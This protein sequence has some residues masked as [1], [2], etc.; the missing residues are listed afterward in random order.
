MKGRT[1]ISLVLLCISVSAAQKPRALSGTS[2]ELNTPLKLAIEKLEPTEFGYN[3]TVR[4]TN[5]GNRALT[6]ALSTPPSGMALQSLD[7][8]Q[9]DDKIGWETAGPCRDV[10]PSA[11]MTLQPKSTMWDVVPIFA[12]SKVCPRRIMGLQGRVRAVLYF[13]YNDQLAFERH[14]PAL[15]NVVSEAVE[16]PPLRQS[17]Q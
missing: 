16:L 10:L 13:A 8:Q 9:W 7:V 12:A 1:I 4:V 11:T 6:L 17:Q 2:R 14:T 5:S 3:V 15:Q